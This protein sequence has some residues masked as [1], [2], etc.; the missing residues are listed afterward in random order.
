M[1]RDFTLP[2]GRV[3]RT[4]VSDEATLQWY[5]QRSEHKGYPDRPPDVDTET[6]RMWVGP[7]HLKEGAALVGSH[8][9]GIYV[10]NL[11][12]GLPI[13]K[14]MISFLQ[15]G[16][17][18]YVR[19]K[20]ESGIAETFGLTL[21]DYDKFIPYGQEDLVNELVDVTLDAMCLLTDLTKAIM[22]ESFEWLIT[23]P[24]D[25]IEWDHLWAEAIEDYRNEYGEAGAPDPR[26]PTP[27]EDEP[28]GWRNGPVH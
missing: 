23:Y 18:Y 22:G 12:P 4:R 9:M 27:N 26:M 11:G 8:P 15:P 10:L 13:I 1:Y 24:S 2:N 3:V 16:E 7:E 6:M 17:G 19:L 28:P 20:M 25:I 14:L 5:H 21:E